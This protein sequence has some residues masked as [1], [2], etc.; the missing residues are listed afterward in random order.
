MQK[1]PSTI[2]GI[3]EATRRLAPL[4][5][6]ELIS[7]IAEELSNEIQHKKLLKPV[8]QYKFCGMWSDRQDMKNSVEWVNKIRADEEQRSYH[9]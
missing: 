5:R 1:K 2:R 4:E 8:T 6:L 3:L 7:I 9:V